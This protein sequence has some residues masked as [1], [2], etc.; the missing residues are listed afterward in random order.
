MM[1]WKGLEGKLLWQIFKI[2]F[3]HLSEVNEENHE[4]PLVRITGLRAQI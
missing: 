1:N 2:V 3:R 4:N